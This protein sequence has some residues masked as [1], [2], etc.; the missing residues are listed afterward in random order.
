[1]NIH[2]YIYIYTLTTSK[3]EDTTRNITT[4][5]TYMNVCNWHYW[6]QSLC[7]RRCCV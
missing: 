2:T 5:T 7:L 1:M 3:E 4:T 6:C